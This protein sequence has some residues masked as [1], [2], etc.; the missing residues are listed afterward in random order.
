MSRRP[1]KFVKALVVASGLAG[2]ASGCGRVGPIDPPT[3]AGQITVADA[4]NSVDA[5]S[6]DAGRFDAGVDAGLT[7]PQCDCGDIP[8]GGGGRPSCNS[9]GLA[10]CCFAVGPLPPPDLAVA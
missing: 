8:D 9:V 1:I 5:G 6:T 10:S 4:G 7:C 2:V 3:D